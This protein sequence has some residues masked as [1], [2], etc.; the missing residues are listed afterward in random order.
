MDI[1]PPNLTH[2]L[3]LELID[4]T[5][6]ARPLEADLAY[7]TRDPYAVVACFGSPATRVCWVF[8][9]SLL[10]RGLF[11][12]TG[13]GD[14]HIWPCLDSYGRAV[15]IIELS[16]PDGV[17][18]MQANSNQVSDFLRETE[19]L[20]PFGAEGLHTDVDRAIAQLLA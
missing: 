6:A 3:T 14:I 8:G 4:A 19:T 10:E 17:A 9:R 2:S 15:T 5:G 20:V 18:L 7:D 12:P 16:S 13:E 11:E 1:A